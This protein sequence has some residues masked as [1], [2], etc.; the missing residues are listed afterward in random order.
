MSKRLHKQRLSFGI[1]FILFLAIAGL[2]VGLIYA[3]FAQSDPVIIIF[4]AIL[5]FPLMYLVGW[6][7]LA[8]KAI[9]KRIQTIR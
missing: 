8:R 3:L 9:V 6:L 7:W 2:T 4:Y 1:F 5:I